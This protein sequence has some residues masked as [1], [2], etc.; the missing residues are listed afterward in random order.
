MAQT[1]EDRVLN[2]YGETALTT[3]EITQIISD[4]AMEVDLRW[5]SALSSVDVSDFDDIDNTDD[6]VERAERLLTCHFMKD[7]EPEQSSASAEGQSVSVAIPT[8][9]I[10]EWLKNTT[11]GRSLYRFLSV[12]GIQVDNHDGSLPRNFG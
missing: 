11:H 4:A 10:D 6:L 2:T 1:D 8:G 7:A 3:S 5:F 9:D 12:L